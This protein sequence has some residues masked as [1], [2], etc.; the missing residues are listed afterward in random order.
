MG[1]VYS[2]TQERVLQTTLLSL[3]NEAVVKTD[4]YRE[5]ASWGEMRYSA[6]YVEECEIYHYV[7]VVRLELRE[8][9]QC[10]M[11]Q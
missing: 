10:P 7:K 3:G 11:I 4:I 5:S 9:C 6:I 8:C 2:A 1:R